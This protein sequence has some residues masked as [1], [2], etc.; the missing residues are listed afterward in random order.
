MAAS[1]RRLIKFPTRIS[2]F[3]IVDRR[4][5]IVSIRH[6]SAKVNLAIPKRRGRTRDKRIAIYSTRDCLHEE[7][8]W[9]FTL[10]WFRSGGCRV[11]AKALHGM[12]RQ[13]RREDD[14]RFAVGEVRQRFHGWSRWGRWRAPGDAPG[15]WGRI[16]RWWPAGR[17]RLGIRTWRPGFGAADI[18]CCG[19][20]AIRTSDP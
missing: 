6:P 8:G 17:R 18:R 1:S 5:P 10:I 14:D 7:N 2:A 4:P 3:F 9:A 11:L 12:E 15:R 16:W 20:M 13:G 19:P